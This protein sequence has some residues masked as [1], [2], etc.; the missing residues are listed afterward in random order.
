M[1]EVMSYGERPYWD[2]SNQDV[3]SK[4]ACS[5]SYN[6]QHWIIELANDIWI[7]VF[8]LATHPKT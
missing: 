5:V 6:A 1:W 2:M 8:S 4:N 3:S 7:R